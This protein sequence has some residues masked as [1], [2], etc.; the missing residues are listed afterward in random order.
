[1]T[2]RNLN[3]KTGLTL[4]ALIS[5]IISGC[6]P[7]KSSIKPGEVWEDDNGLFINA[8]GGGVLYHDG[9]YYLYGEMKEGETY[10]P[11]CNKSWGGTRVDVTGVS[12]YSSND[13]FNW[14][15]EGVVLP[16]VEDDPSHDLYKGN[17][18]ERPKVIYNA[19]TNKFV[20]WMHVDSKD[21]SK[22]AAGVAVSNFPTGPFEYIES[23]RPN[24]GV[25]PV[26]A[27]E[28]DTTEG[29]LARDFEGG[30][31]ARDM[32]IF[33]DDDEKAYQFYSSENN[34][35]M[36]ISELTDDYLRPTGKYKRVFPGRKMEA[37]AV[38]KK[39][40]RYYFIASG[41]TAWE[42]NPA[43]SAVAESIWGPWE[44]LGN[45]CIGEGAEKTFTSQ[46]TYVLP[47]QGK[48]D[49]FIFMADRWNK[50]DLPDSRYIWLP[51]KFDESGKIV[52]EWHD[53]WDLSVFDK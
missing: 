44:E 26:N 35:T 25:W 24:A 47:V 18:L 43:R 8:H 36:H 28:A 34:A 14:K 31:M 19:K 11:E 13:L 46:S 2:M 41:C 32:T 42:P 30:Q 50:D 1:M 21:Y 16:A 27:A 12:C 6:Q 53:E 20:M 23:F 3:M 22:A 52:L 10:L 33:V 5:L 7:Q 29:I 45:P 37:P 9:T 40:G 49:A 15:Y 48:S 39:E 51:I 4:F 17:V 38:F